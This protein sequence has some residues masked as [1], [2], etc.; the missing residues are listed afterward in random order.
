VL[1][2]ARQ[3][4][5]TSAQVI[6]DLIQDTY[7]KLCADRLRVLQNFKSA[8]KDAIY[9]YIKVITANLV[10]DH[11]K[12]ARSL[13]RGGG[14]TAASID[15]REPGQMLPTAVSAPAALDRYVLIQEIDARLKV[16][17][18]GPESE[19]DRQIFWLYYRVGLTASAIA[20]LPKIGLG[21][22]GV[23]SV[24]L[25]L[26]REVRQQLAPDSGRASDSDRL[27]GIR[28]AESL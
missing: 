10:H 14:A 25:R 28:P 3:W 26:T 4:G 6:D 23:E 1:R 17:A 19:R 2:V 24:L 7:L 12:I 20:A 15:G 8:H 13:K 11:F 21:A 5:E 27:E 22:K 18:A 16:V 9:G